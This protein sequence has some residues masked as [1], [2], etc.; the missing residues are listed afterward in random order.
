MSRKHFSQT[1]VI[2]FCKETEVLYGASEITIET[3]ITELTG[4]LTSIFLFSASG[5]ICFML[6]S[7]NRNLLNV[8]FGEWNYCTYLL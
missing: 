1:Q 6:E 2:Y 8:T 4:L 7:L 5:Y 3:V